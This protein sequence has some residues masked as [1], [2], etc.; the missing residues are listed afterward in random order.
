MFEASFGSNILASFTEFHCQGTDTFG[1]IRVQTFQ[2]H[3][4]GNVLHKQYM[5]TCKT[6][7]KYLHNFL[8]FEFTLVK[9]T[10]LTLNVPIPDKVK[11]LS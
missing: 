1:F 9:Q 4:Q 10:A 2:I 8:R 11:T 7:L 3:I 5:D 6:F